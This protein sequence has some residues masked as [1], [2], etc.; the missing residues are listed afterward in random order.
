[1]QLKACEVE[2]PQ[3]PVGAARTPGKAGGEG[4]L[5]GGRSKDRGQDP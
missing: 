2:G 1:M 4:V 3:S 5:G